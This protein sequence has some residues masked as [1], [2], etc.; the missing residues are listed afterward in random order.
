MEAPTPVSAYLHSAT[1][2]KL[3][4]I[5]LHALHLFSRFLKYGFGSLL[6][7]GLLTLFWGSFFAVKQTDLKAILAFSTVSQL[8]LIMS[9]LG[10]GAM[11]YHVDDAAFLNLQHSLR[12]SI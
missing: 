10:A 4:F 6:V 12:F 2:V 3:V 11:A 7:L 9:L 1:M 8:G 5:L